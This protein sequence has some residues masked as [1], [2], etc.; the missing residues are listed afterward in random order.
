MKTL[1]FIKIWLIGCEKIQFFNSSGDIDQTFD[2]ANFEYFHKKANA[3]AIEKCSGLYCHL[4]YE[5]NRMYDEN[6]EEFNIYV[7]D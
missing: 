5:L 2:K 4:K 3:N 6:E 1:L 7:S